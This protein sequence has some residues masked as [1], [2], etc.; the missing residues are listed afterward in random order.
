MQEGIWVDGMVKCSAV[1]DKNR[2]FASEPTPYPIPLLELLQPV[3]VLREAAA[4]FVTLIP[5]QYRQAGRDG[6]LRLLHVLVT[7][8][9]ASEPGTEPPPVTRP[10]PTHRL[11]RCQHRHSLERCA[12]DLRAIANSWAWIIMKF[13]VNIINIIMR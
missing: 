11:Q 13:I 6:L 3:A 10:P 9:V 5:E 4:E 2:L 1:E 12:R 8:S 7:S